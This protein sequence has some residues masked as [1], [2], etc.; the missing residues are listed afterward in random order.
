MKQLLVLILII[1]FV[2]PVFGDEVA[3]PNFSKPPTEYIYHHT[4]QDA[5]GEKVDTE[6][7]LLIGNRDNHKLTFWF[8]ITAQNF[9]VCSMAGIATA[10]KKNEYVFIEDTCKLTIKITDQEVQLFDP[11]DKCKKRN[12]GMYAHINGLKF[13]KKR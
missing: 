2:L 7:E 5:I 13:K 3:R 4:V 12:C 11:N 6:D 8:Y 1:I 9:H 10:T